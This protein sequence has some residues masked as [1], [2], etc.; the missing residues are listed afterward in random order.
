MDSTSKLWIDLEEY[1]CKSNPILALYVV[2]VWSC[3]V[4][5][6]SKLLLH[7]GGTPVSRLMLASFIKLTRDL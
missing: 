5:V 2:V 7:C 4:V 1:A 6:M 3:V